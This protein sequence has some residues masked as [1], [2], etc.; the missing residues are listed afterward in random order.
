M[1][2]EKLARQSGAIFQ[3]NMESDRPLSLCFMLGTY[4]W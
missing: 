2:D 1:S 4:E 3:A